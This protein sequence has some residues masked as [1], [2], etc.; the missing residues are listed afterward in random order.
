M[1]E[2][3]AARNPDPATRRGALVVNGQRA[4]ITQDAGA[5]DITLGASSASFAPAGGS[6][7]VDVRASSSLCQWT[8]T[9]TDSWI[10]IRSATEG[11]GNGT[12]MFDVAATSGPPRAAALTIAGQ[13][14]SITQ[15]EGCTFSIAP[16]S[17]STAASGGSTTVNVTTA[18][19]CPWMA[20]SNVPWMSI[21]PSEGSGPGAV[22]VTVSA[23]NG[24]SRE[25]TAVIAGQLFSESQSDG[26]SFQVQPLSHSVGSAGGSESVT[27]R[28]TA[29]CEW[30]ASSDAPWI[31]IQTGSAGSGNGTVTFAVEASTGAARSGTLTVAGQKVSVQ[32]A[33]G[34]TFS[35]NPTQES[36]PAA[37]GG[38]RVTVTAPDGC[39]WTASSNASWLTIT[40]G[41]SGSGG[42]TVQYT[43]AATSGPSRSGTLTVAGQTLTVNQGQGCSF[44]LVPASA[45]V[46]NAGG[47]TSFDVQAASGCG[48]TA[49]S[50][51][52]WITI[53]SGGTGTGNGTVQLAVAAN[54][55]GSRTGNVTVADK[56]FAVTQGSGCT[57]GLSATSTNVPQQGGAASVGVTAA[58]GCDWTAVSNAPWL[59]I[60][61]GASGS[62]SGTVNF[63]AAPNMG[64]GRVG[65]LTIAGQTFTVNQGAACSFAIAP[66]QQTIAAAGG[67]TTV[68]VTAGGGCAWTAA[69]NAPWITVASGASGSGNGSV[70]LSI[71]ANTGADRVGTATIAGRTFTVNQS[72]GCTFTVNPELLTPTAAG[73]AT[74][75]DV[76]AAAACAWTAT[77]SMPWITISSGASGSGNGRVNFSVGANTGPPRTG[78]LLVAGRTVTVNQSS[79][80]TFALSATSTTIP[81]NGGSGSV[82]VIAGA[83]CSW[84][85]VSQVPW[86]VVTSGASGSGNG[87]V[88]FT[89]QARMSGG[90]RSGTIVIAGQTFTV[91]QN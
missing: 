43:A 16:Q 18:V 20:A 1:V 13:R 51:A 7:R 44:A 46:P 29:G 24:P 90:P 30:S 5:C 66:E 14:F 6:G 39:A 23:V 60:T 12:V 64:P 56:T 81:Q 61:S 19:G 10:Q 86:I 48:W 83:G 82:N 27:V 17:H 70:Q 8:V 63:T 71:A 32:Q 57:F 42:G 38:G 68:M 41:A 52:P 37:G 59:S 54:S 67:S 34:C 3:A 88:Q 78:T 91:N 72:A 58:G 28:S 53:A 76:T 73:G 22:V 4:E 36:I 55:A 26:C 80:C 40:S 21:S 75:V 65:T 69:S 2:F 62:G 87:T 89:V 31:T 9:S 79:G 49:A 74:G 84:T 11:R 15:S 47:Q 25:G 33:Q 45:T 77:T 50:Q 85:A 35:I